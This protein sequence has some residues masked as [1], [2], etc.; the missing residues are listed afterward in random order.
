MQNLDLLHQVPPDYRPQLQE[1]KWIKSKYGKA[2]TII[3]LGQGNFMDLEIQKSE[4][5]RQQKEYKILLKFL[6]DDLLQQLSLAADYI[7]SNNSLV[8][9]WRSQRKQLQTLKVEVSEARRTSSEIDNAR[10]IYRSSP[11]RLS[12]ASYS[13]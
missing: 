12:V 3:R 8:R 9:I 7:L 1:L 10:E 6:E 13:R 2:L 11:V 5:T 4:L